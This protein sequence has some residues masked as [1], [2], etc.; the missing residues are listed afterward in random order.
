MTRSEERGGLFNRTL[1]LKVFALLMFVA[2]LSLGTINMT[3]GSGD[4]RD[5][6][7]I[8]IWSIEDLRKIGNDPDYPLNGN[9]VMMGDIDASITQS[10]P[11]IP[12]G[13][14]SNP[15]TGK[16]DGGLNAIRNLNINISITG[17]SA[18]GLFG[19]VS[20]DAEIMNLSLI[21]ATI[22]SRGVDNI[23]TG[24]LIGIM[25][26]IVSG[27]VIVSNCHVTYSTS[28][29]TMV[30]SDY[31][32]GGIVGYIE[33]K[34]T[35]SIT[36]CS[37]SSITITGNCATGGIV[38]Y[39]DSYSAVRISDCNV[40]NVIVF[41]HGKYA[42]SG[43]IVGHMEMANDCKIVDCIV[44]DGTDIKAYGDCST[45]GGI[46]GYM[47]GHSNT[48]SIVDC[49]VEVVAIKAEGIV[50]RAGGII[51]YGER[52]SIVGCTAGSYDHVYAVNAQ[53]TSSAR[54]G[55][56]VGQGEDL[57]IEGCNN[58]LDVFSHSTIMLSLSTDAGG[59]AGRLISSVVL[60]SNNRGFISNA[61]T[62]NTNASVNSSNGG[63][64]GYVGSNTYLTGCSNEGAIC[65][66]AS[67][68]SYAGGIVGFA[69]S[70]NANM[71]KVKECV[72]T[73]GV[74]SFAINNRAGGIFGFARGTTAVDCKNSG[75]VFGSTSDTT[76]T[77]YVG[78]IIGRLEA[79][80]LDGCVNLSGGI[81]SIANIGAPGGSSKYW[82]GG[83]AGDMTYG[84]SIVKCV[85]GGQVSIEAPISASH[86]YVGGLVGHMYS[87][88]SIAD[89]TN[90]G[91]ISGQGESMAGLFSYVGGVAGAAKGSSISPIGMNGCK[92]YGDILS[93]AAN[94]RVGGIIGYGCYVTVMGCDNTGNVDGIGG[95]VEYGISAA[96]VRSGG[97]AGYLEHSKLFN[98]TS[99]G[100]VS[101]T[102]L[103]TYG[104]AR[105]GGIV[106]SMVMETSLSGCMAFGTITST[107]G[108]H[109]YGTSYAGGI[110]GFSE[111]TI[112]SCTFGQSTKWGSVTSIGD[113]SGAGGLVGMVGSGT[114]SGVAFVDVLVEHDS[115]QSGRA[116]V[117]AGI[118]MKGA[119]VTFTGSKGTAV[120]NV[121]S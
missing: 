23:P 33:S 93:N 31:K 102:A 89:S 39:I 103:N 121:V 74:I 80:I 16:F 75:E 21:G 105:A 38:G 44:S 10:S 53:A 107:A 64:V 118:V 100:D 71:I 61:N 51:G 46:V 41:S 113:K 6:D 83:I 43:G 120:T 62:F 77:V 11:F 9:Y 106:G 112:A 82:F 58:Y 114:V 91:A 55:G 117:G 73:G 40:L 57:H 95:S 37:T 111:G 84:S 98:C 116:G 25:T 3:E 22:D 79:S 94:A 26:S 18:A 72:N 97:V 1:N 78:G 76:M 2:M 88:T 42:V 92:N 90:N 101:A 50:A 68:F 60:N 96:S 17:G 99:L 13:E 104:L 5:S 59:I 36:G 19:Y 27:H 34:M 87:G 8:E 28:Y 56:I 52:L 67:E 119:K 48:N 4:S 108:M 7:A 49:I 69:T 32:T 65:A 35:V 110:A 81:I 66:I 15:F 29:P 115:T 70:P 24:G 86:L 54:A 47:V 12:I 45:V 20:G 30:D 14:K 85:N 109:M 63:I